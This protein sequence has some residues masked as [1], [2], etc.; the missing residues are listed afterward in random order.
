M[1]EF[2]PSRNFTEK[3]MQSVYDFET[4]RKSSPASLWGLL[5]MRVIRYG[6]AVGGAILGI[7]NIVRLC[8]PFIMPAVC[9]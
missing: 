9:H 3:V 1:K 2:E 6:L 5:S 4:S 8:F 7:F